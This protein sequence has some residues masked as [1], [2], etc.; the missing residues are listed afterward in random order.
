MKVFP[1]QWG[2]RQ[3]QE[4]N[5]LFYLGRSLGERKLTDHTKLIFKMWLETKEKIETR[6]E[7]IPIGSV[8]SKETQVYDEWLQ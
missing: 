4:K 7:R 1:N 3:G 5:G 6:L 8:S 2:T